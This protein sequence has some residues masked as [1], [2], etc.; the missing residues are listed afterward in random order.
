MEPSVFEA[1]RTA[2]LAGLVTFWLAPALLAQ[3]AACETPVLVVSGFG[4][5][6]ADPQAWALLEAAQGKVAGLNAGGGEGDARQRPE[7]VIPGEA[8]SPEKGASSEEALGLQTALAVGQRVRILT[9][10]ATGQVGAVSQLEA[11]LMF[12]SGFAYP[13]A[14]IDL[15]DGQQVQVPQRNLVILGR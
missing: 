7:L 2:D 5:G 1:V 9:G 12:E 3:A 11:P 14:T 4:E 13:T 10:A 6:V 8:V 15:I